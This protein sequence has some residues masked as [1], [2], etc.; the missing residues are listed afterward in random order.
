M[1]CQFPEHHQSSG[2]G[3]GLVLAGIL[4]LVA[5][6]G[7]VARAVIHA[8]EVALT[9]IIITAGCLAAAGLVAVAAVVAVRLRRRQLAARPPVR[10]VRS[11]PVQG[12]PASRPRAIGAPRAVAQPS[13]H[14]NRERIPRVP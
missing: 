5:I 13:P 7:A 11:R 6:V 4:V 12:L 3:G 8:L 14:V 9:I 2:G 10:L 1:P